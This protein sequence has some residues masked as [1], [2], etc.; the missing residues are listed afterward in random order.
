MSDRAA[1]F[2][3]LYKE[4]RIA[5][6]LKFYDD[7]SKEYEAAHRQAIAVRNTLLVLAAVA[8]AAGQFA[9][10]TGRA[11]CGVV[12]AVLAALAGAVTAF[13]SLIG[14][15]QLHKLYSDAALNLAAVEIDW[16]AGST[17]GDVAD[18]VERVERIFR[19]ENGQWGQLVVEGTAKGAP[20]VSRGEP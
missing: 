2:R 12:A 10:G 6:Q 19:S 7:R 1:Q 9:T 4:L 8:G 20:A 5:D 17:D 15:P 13:E 16:D 18:E 14:F 3:A 11:A